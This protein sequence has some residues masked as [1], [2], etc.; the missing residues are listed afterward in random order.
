[1]VMEA[2]ENNTELNLKYGLEYNGYELIFYH[3]IKF[4]EGEEFVDP[5]AGLYDD[6]KEPGTYEFDLY[7]EIEVPKESNFFWN[8]YS[9]EDAYESIKETLGMTTYELY[10]NKYEFESYFISPDG[11]ETDGNSSLNLNVGGLTLGWSICNPNEADNNFN[12]F[13]WNYDITTIENGKEISYKY[14]IEY[15][16]YELVFNHTIKFKWAESAE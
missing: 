2:A 9:I 8:V 11:T 4:V 12:L 13:S 6:P 1:M 10:C 14:V 3:T 16:E 15:K 5:E 7:D